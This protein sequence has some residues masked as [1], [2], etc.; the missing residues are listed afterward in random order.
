MSVDTISLEDETQQHIRLI[1]SLSG[2]EDLLQ[3][4]ASIEDADERKAKELQHYS[5][6]PFPTIPPFNDKHALETTPT[7]K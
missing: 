1:P 6:N 2:P 5:P 7:A 4:Q 3:S